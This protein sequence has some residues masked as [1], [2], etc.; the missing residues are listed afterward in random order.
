MKTAHL[1]TPDYI[2]QQ[3]APHWICACSGCHGE[4]PL[5]EIRWQNEQRR[6]WDLRCDSAAAAILCDAHAFDMH[7]ETTE[8]LPLA[9]CCPRLYALNQQVY[10]T[11][12]NSA[13]PLNETLY[14]I[15]L[16]IS[17]G[18]RLQTAEAI[19]ALGDELQSIMEAGALS[20]AFDA[21]PLIDTFALTAMRQLGARRLEAKLDARTGMTL[22]MTLSELRLLEDARLLG[23]LS[24]QRGD[25]KLD[26][27]LADH[28]TLWRNYLRWYV[29]HHVFPGSDENTWEAAFLQL[30]QSVFSV[31]FLVS[32]LLA[33]GCEVN[34]Q[35]L[36]ALLAGWHREALPAVE[37]ENALLVGLSLLK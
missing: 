18:Q 15:G 25:I 7:I 27:W 14:A 20:E 33:A 13:R 29:W 34:T 19:C 5:H 24:A 8:P 35:T 2:M 11:L 16:L 4:K 10:R 23:L 37:A 17:R 30:C 36:V 3:A 28:D 9:S 31:Q 6:S 12:L 32:Q 22:M 1:F 21:L 26:V